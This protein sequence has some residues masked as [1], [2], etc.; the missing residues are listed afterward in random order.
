MGGVFTAVIGLL[1]VWILVIQ[2]KLMV[3][4]G[5]DTITTNDTKTDFKD[6]GVVTMEDLKFK[7]PVFAINYKNILLKS[8]DE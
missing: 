6:L 5:N 3:T 1:I 2:I 4:F 8:Y 7:N